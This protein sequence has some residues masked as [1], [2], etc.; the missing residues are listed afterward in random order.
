MTVQNFDQIVAF[1][2]EN[3]EALVKSGSLAVKG[4]EELTKAYTTLANQSIEQ[5][6]SAVKALTSAKNPGEFQSIYGDLAKSNFEALFS[7]S[8]KIQELANS[9]V[10][11][12]F[13]PLNARVQ[14]LSGIFKA[15]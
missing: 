1:S 4:L 9:V 5:T 3:V 11:S 14:A 13:A 12:S 7:E 15:A 6:S 2:K 8:R 10:T